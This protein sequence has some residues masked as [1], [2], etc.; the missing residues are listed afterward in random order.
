M[1]W[2]Q[3][4]RVIQV[5]SDSKLAL[6]LVN[7]R[8]DPVH[9]YATLLA[10]IRRFLAQDW[11]VRL[12]HTYREGNRVADW[13]SKHSLVYPYGMYELSNPPNELTRLLNDDVRGITFTR[14][15]VVS[16]PSPSA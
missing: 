3:G 15:V 13:L 16:T 10:A 1:A 14:N 7:K 6:E 11:V 2:K 9:P 8:T 12:S 5:E 4:C